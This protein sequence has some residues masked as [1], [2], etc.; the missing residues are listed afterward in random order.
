NKLLEFWRILSFPLLIVLFFLFPFLHKKGRK[1]WLLGLLL[2]FSL[3]GSLYFSQ[4][5]EE[6]YLI[7]YHFVLLVWGIPSAIKVWK[8]LLKRS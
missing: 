8:W 6:R 4:P 2:L 1:E 3:W 5:G 7:P